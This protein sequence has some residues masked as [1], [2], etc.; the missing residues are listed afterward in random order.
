MTT[1]QLVLKRLNILIP[2]TAVP[3]RAV[4]TAEVG[5]APPQGSR[6]GLLVWEWTPSP[7]STPCGFYCGDR[8]Q[9][10]FRS[11]ELRSWSLLESP[12]QVSSRLAGCSLPALRHLLGAVWDRCF[13]LA[14]K[15][16]YARWGWVFPCGFDGGACSLSTGV[17]PPKKSHHCMGYR[18][19]KRDFFFSC[20]LS[21]Q[22]LV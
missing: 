22:G 11:L 20:I 18:T 3:L 9:P 6:G 5:A 7:F 2:S 13:K 10:S 21:F 4:S 17:I 8:A 19:K 16:F 15:D 1:H 14:P 12:T